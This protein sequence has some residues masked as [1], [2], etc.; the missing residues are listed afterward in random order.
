M[1]NDYRK[2]KKERK[3]KKCYKYNKVG[4]CKGTTNFKVQSQ[5]LGVCNTDFYIQSPIPKL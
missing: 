2:P 1:E 3:T 4:Y 5:K